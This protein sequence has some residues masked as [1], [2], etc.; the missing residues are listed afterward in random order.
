MLIRSILSL[1]MT[2]GLGSGSPIG[3][4]LVEEMASRCKWK[5]RFE[6]FPFELSELT[7]SFLSPTDMDV[8][9]TREATGSFNR[10]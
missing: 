3:P 10:I 4:G 5:R 1:S 2:D 9:S 8:V 7:R 6:P